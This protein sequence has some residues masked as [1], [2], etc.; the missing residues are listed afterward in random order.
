MTKADWYKIME[1]KFDRNNLSPLKEAREW[2]RMW[3]VDE[4]GD[5][6]YADFILWCQKNNQLASYYESEKAIYGIENWCWWKG[7]HRVKDEY[8]LNA[9]EDDIWEEL[10][11]FLGM[12]TDYNF[13]SYRTLQQ[14]DEALFKARNSVKKKQTEESKC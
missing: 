3:L 10:P 6:E 12:S 4:E 14:A 2:F 1:D 13:R 8:I 11:E 9:I 5:E 7:E